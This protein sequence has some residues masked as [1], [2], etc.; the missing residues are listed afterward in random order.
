MKPGNNTRFFLN[1]FSV[2]MIVYGASALPCVLVAAYFDEQS[3]L[4]PLGL[5]SAS[6]IVSGIV[7]RRL[8]NMESGIVRPR[9][10]YLTTIVSWLIIIAITTVV[11]FYGRAEFTWID[12]FF[13]ATASLTTTGMGN[14]D[15]RVYPFSLQLW[16]SILNWLGGVGIILIS[17]SCLSSWNFSGHALMSVEIPGPEFVKS[18][19]TFRN[20]Y[21]NI[22]FIYV[23][24][25]AVH[26][27]VLCLAGMTPF[28]SLLTA[29]SN[30]S[31]AGMQH[32][33]NGVIIH[34][35]VAQKIIITVFAFLGSVNVSFF[36]LLFIHKARLVNKR[37]EVRLYLDRILLTSIII[38][39]AIAIIDNRS[40]FSSL[41][42]SIMQTVAFLSTS[43]YIVADCHEWPLLC[44]LLILLQMF[45]GG[46]AVSTAGGI[47]IAR[48]EIGIKTV[49][50]GLFRHVHPNA[51]KPVKFN[52]ESLKSDQLVQANLFISLFMC[53]YIF[54]ALILAL[55]NKNES[56]FDALN[57]SQAMLTNTGT[58]IAELDSPGLA[59]RFSPLSK[60]VMSFEMLCGRLEIYPVLMLFMKSFWKSDNSR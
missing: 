46:C 30:I 3:A 13:E 40:F 39:A 42:D 12:S 25:T 60:I 33:H 22:I 11:Y 16:R 47:K 35:P 2:V 9:M 49:A 27:V 58:S 1:I 19:V 7:I 31:T 4:G 57:F 14:L 54:S 28:M 36:I 53:I 56:I 24:L 52:N 43:G 51:I 18:S 23:V 10:N 50:F 21:R 48:I 37:T 34:L 45:I 8:F 26:F 55:D 20:T 15:V 6:C 32:I 5:A 29:L 17:V 41:G 44:Q 38:A 59:A